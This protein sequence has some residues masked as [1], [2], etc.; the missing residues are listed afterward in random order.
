LS[1]VFLSVFCPRRVQYGEAAIHQAAAFGSVSILQMLLDKGESVRV[2]VRVR[3]GVRVRV[4]VG[5]GVR[6]R[7]RVRFKG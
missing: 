3:V 5:V 4:R 1:I 7:V 6:V 2:R